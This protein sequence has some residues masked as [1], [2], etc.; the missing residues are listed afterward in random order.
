[1]ILYPAT[2]LRTERFVSYTPTHVDTMNLKGK[3]NTHH[4]EMKA[5]T[6]NLSNVNVIKIPGLWIALW[7]PKSHKS[8]CS[9]TQRLD[10]NLQFSIINNMQPSFKTKIPG[11]SRPSITKT[12]QESALLVGAGLRRLDPNL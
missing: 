7:L 10:L 9:S 11:P 2:T 6:I 1:M 3:K 12:S 5:Y 8:W 4:L